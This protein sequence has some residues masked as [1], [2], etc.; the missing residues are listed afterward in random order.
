MIPTFLVTIITLLILTTFTAMSSN[1]GQVEAKTVVDPNCGVLD[2]KPSGK[3]DVTVDYDGECSPNA[4]NCNININVIT[5]PPPSGK[6][7][8]KLKYLLETGIACN[9]VKS[10]F[11]AQCL[12]AS[13]PK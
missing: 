11:K 3:C 10:S 13:K 1:V 8:L 7:E 2:Q 5:N 12:L 9:K 4:P 6:K